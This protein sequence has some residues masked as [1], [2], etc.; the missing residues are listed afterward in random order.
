MEKQA[1][2]N[3]TKY[4]IAQQVAKDILIAKE[5]KE[6]NI[7]RWQTL[8]DIFKADSNKEN[9]P[10]PLAMIVYASLLNNSIRNLSLVSDSK[11]FTYELQ[12]S[13]FANIVS[14]PEAIVFLRQQ[15]CKC[16]PLGDNQYANKVNIVNALTID[17]FPNSIEVLQGYIRSLQEVTVDFTNTTVQFEFEEEDYN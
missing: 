12:P 6:D 7:S 9:Y 8:V 15:L 4:E 1:L 13:D 2:N 16:I 11:A 10:L 14:Q 3:A 5:E 17:Q